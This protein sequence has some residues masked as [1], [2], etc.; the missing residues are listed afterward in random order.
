MTNSGC[1]FLQENLEISLSFKVNLQFQEKD[2]GGCTTKRFWILGNL[3]R[4][5]NMARIWYWW[6]NHFLLERIK[7][8]KHQLQVLPVCLG[9]GYSPTSI[10]QHLILKVQ[11]WL[12]WLNCSLPA[13]FRNLLFSRLMHLREAHP[14]SGRYRP[15]HPIMRCFQPMCVWSF[16]LPF[17][18]LTP[19]LK[20]L[21]APLSRHSL[22][23][24]W[25]AWLSPACSACPPPAKIT[26]CAVA[27]LPPARASHHL[28]NS[29]IFPLILTL[30][31]KQYTHTH[32]SVNWRKQM[33]SVGVG[34]LVFN[35]VKQ[36]IHNK[37]IAKH[38]SPLLTLGS[39]CDWRFQ[40]YP[41][42]SALEDEWLY[43]KY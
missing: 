16:S 43:P 39:C 6:S 31:L 9:F 12:N 7:R 4:Y 42:A 32:G 23:F 8:R 22:D 24:S 26:L 13:L 29:R 20:M 35:Q 34:F 17:H 21:H 15:I 14:F 5:L 18:W 10:L 30:S 11:A 36:N 1:A 25:A 27:H 19:P 38:S 37:W 33:H 2:R 28:L 3:V 41:G 40:A